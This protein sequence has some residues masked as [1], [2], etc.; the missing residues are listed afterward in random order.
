MFYQLPPVGNPICLSR[1][2][3][4]E[5]LLQ[6]VFR[7]YVPK[8]YASGTAALAAAILAA[9]KLKGVSTPEVILPAYGCP[10]LVSAAVFAGAKPVLVDLEPDRPWMDLDQVSGHANTHTVAIIAASL[11][12]I[13]ERMD[14]LRKI[15]EACSVLLIEDSAQAFPVQNDGSFWTGDLVALS[16]GRGKPVSLL[17]G[18]ALLFREEVL[19]DLMPEDVDKSRVKYSKQALFRLKAVLYNLMITPGMYWIPQGLPFLHLGETQYKPLSGIDAMDSVRCGL[20]AVN[21]DKYQQY[22]AIVQVS[23]ANLMQEP[24]IA[25]K[26]IIDLPAVCRAPQHQRLLRYPLLVE[27]EYREWI[28]HCLRH[29]GLG[30]SRM[31]PASLPGIPGLETLLESQGTF[32]AAEDFARCVLTLP[33]HSRAR[34]VDI[35]KIRRAFTSRGR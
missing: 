23:L 33:T 34:S 14:A 30:P 19:A 15:A 9:I 7:P 27:P 16:F 20:L 8:F 5:T 29:E 17:G 13:P 22:N 31:Y 12:G 6:D 18:G 2:S 10:D 24:D 4:D 28:Y 11:C 1:S 32:P 35:R 3:A 25:G 26:G 21:V